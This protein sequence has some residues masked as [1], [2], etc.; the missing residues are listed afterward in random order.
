MGTAYNYVRGTLEKRFWAKVKKGELDACW[1]WQA[2]LDSRGY[3]NIGVP[4]N[5]GTGRYIM[6]R[7]HRIAFLLANGSIDI[8][9]VVRHSCDNR[10][11]CNPAHLSLGTQSENMIDAV[12][13]GRLLRAGENNG[14]AKLRKEDIAAIRCSTASL[15]ALAERYGVSKS[16]VSSARSGQTWT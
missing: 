2:S 9:L 8:D 11:C 3:G 6:Q 13:R 14:R 16:T 4:R 10:R 15:R 1:E 12:E 5:D 7:A